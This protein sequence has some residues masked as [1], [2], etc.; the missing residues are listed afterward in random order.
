MAY[1]GYL[2]SHSIAF[3]NGMHHCCIFFQLSHF[4]Q[5]YPPPL[6]LHLFR[7]CIFFSSPFSVALTAAAQM[8]AILFASQNSPTVQA[9]QKQGGKR[10]AHCR[11]EKNNINNNNNVPMFDTK[12]TLDKHDGKI[13]GK[14]FILEN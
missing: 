13:F 4:P 8:G 6:Q 14:I 9:R 12:I 1:V 11:P 5:A 7:C 10:G 2:L 3:N